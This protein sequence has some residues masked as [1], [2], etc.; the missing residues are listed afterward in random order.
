MRFTFEHESIIV[1]GEI[2][3]EVGTGGRAGWSMQSTCWK[4][5]VQFVTQAHRTADTVLPVPGIPRSRSPRG[6]SPT[7]NSGK[8]KYLNKILFIFS[9]CKVPKPVSNQ[10]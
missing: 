6:G 2:K 9:F 7:L 5:N 4:R 8:N 3:S 10:S 1:I